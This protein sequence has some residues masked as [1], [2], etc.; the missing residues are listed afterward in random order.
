MIKNYFKIAWRNIIKSRFYSLVNII[1]LSTGIAFTLLIGAYVWSEL[2]VNTKLK[3]A[4][5]QYIIQSKWKDP[6]GGYGIATLGPLAKALR[7]SY[8]DLVANYYRFDGITS[9][10]SKGNNSFRENIAICDSTMLNM[11]G[12][13]LM[14][15]NAKT[16]LNEP[17]S[18]I[19]TSNKA[20][21]YFGKT[22]VVGQTLTI[23]SF[24]GSKHDFMITGVLNTIQKNSVI[25][26]VD[27]YPNDF[28]ISTSNLAF[29]G[30]NMDWSNPSIAN[31]IELQKGISPKQLEKPIA[32]LVKE[33]A[34]PQIAGNMT[35]YLVFLK[36]Y[37][38]N[39]N[40]G[41]VK[42]MLYALSVVALFILLMGMINFINMSV[43]RSAA[44]MRE[45][46]IRKV[47][48]G[49]K[50]Q[51][52]FQF[53][54]E[55]VILVFVSTVFA[56]L[57]YGLTQNLFS[58]ILGKE[59][60]AITD[61]PFYFIIF[62]ILLIFCI[63]LIAGIYPA[64]ILSSLKSVDSLK[65]K[66]SSIKENIWL[67]KSLVAFQFGTATIAFVGAIIISKQINL[68]LSKDLGYN[69]EYIVSS[70]VPRNWNREGVNKMENIRRELV[71]VNG[72]KSATL[73]YE[74]PDGNNGGQAPVYKLGND[75]TQSIAT[76]VLV[77]DENY[78]NVYQIP[79]KAGSFFEGNGLDSGKVILN[80]TSIKALGY[81]NANEAIGGQVRI[82]GDPT[83]FTIKGVANDF[84]FGSKQQQIPP[85]IFFNVQFATQY[86][87][88]SFKMQPGNIVST[89]AAL[90]KKWATLMPG[91]PFDYKFMDETLANLYKS[92]IQLKKASYTATVLSL[93]IVLLGV[94]G[95]ISLSIQKRTKEIGI[96]KIL[97]SSVLD[98]IGLFMKDFLGVILIAGVI[99]CPVAWLIMNG[100][101][102]DYAYRISI[103]VLPFLISI[104]ALS[105]M[106][107][108]LI[109][110]Q[111]IK[112][113]SDNPVK[114][115]RTE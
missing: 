45:I 42:K 1:G 86:R 115:L 58:K 102:N 105:F 55:S 22:D 28:F 91:A 14:H 44:R 80:E 69:K 52:I 111:T 81:Q 101:L 38:F 70:Q 93:I 78:L 83:I 26:L 29:F 84:H 75:S 103:T 35:P 11:Y 65:G 8:P 37:Y 64:F 9:N 54:T 23:E 87:Y 100:W 88:L 16:A 60:P 72:V 31:Y 12:F 50:T 59:I 62:P 25:Q 110:I 2:Q 73:S 56:L 107:A 71:K 97:G 7:E 106:T 109:A 74:I 92:E 57:F 20:I 51:L 3:N 33:N 95:L 61:F 41:L 108:L 113:A 17:F 112:A 90:Q 99:A 114:N 24:S 34:P 32:Y 10:V 85:I 82:P 53:L 39:T 43:S 15:G 40:N 96:R 30:R 104:V 94:L 49:L 98:I 89:I 63:G 48:G 68:F 6:N 46:G 27:A 21:K 66:L 77:S 19:L 79:L 5:R 36:D 4:G 47:L 13:S 67:R 76:Q 18:V